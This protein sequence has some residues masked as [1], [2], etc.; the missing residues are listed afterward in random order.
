MLGEVVDTLGKHRD[1][2]FGATGIGSRC[3]VGGDDLLLLRTF[4]CH[5]ALPYL[6]RGGYRSFTRELTYPTGE[7]YQRGPNRPN[8]GGFYA[9]AHAERGALP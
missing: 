7:I 1:L 9:Q 5:G 3:A 2:S 4:E 6:S 8:W